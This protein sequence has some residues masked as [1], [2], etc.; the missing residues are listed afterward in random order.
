MKKKQNIIRL[1]SLVL[2]VV[3]ILQLLPM[4]A[5]SADET[6]GTYGLYLT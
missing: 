3:M 2:S 4:S 1:F 5:F 6:S